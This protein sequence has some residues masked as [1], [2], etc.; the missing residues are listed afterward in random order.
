MAWK[1]FCLVIFI[2]LALPAA[3]CARPRP[4]NSG[5]PP[6]NPPGREEPAAEL[7]GAQLVEN[8][9]AKCHTLERV[10][11]A[12][13]AE[14]WPAVVNRMVDRSPGLLNSDEFALVVEF[15]QKNYAK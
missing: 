9:C 10:Y 13:D 4:D 7:D 6:A 14:Q 2:A 3:G 15:L 8:R 12:R 1:K 11:Q 5:T